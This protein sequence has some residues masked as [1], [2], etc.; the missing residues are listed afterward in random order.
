MMSQ[1]V[2]TSGQAINAQILANRV[3][4]LTQEHMEWTQN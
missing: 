1:N 4:G 2:G 3:Q